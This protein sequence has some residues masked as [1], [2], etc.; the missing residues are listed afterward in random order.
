MDSNRTFIFNLT[1][2]GD[3][4]FKNQIGQSEISQHL[5]WTLV[6]DI[7][8]TLSNRVKWIYLSVKSHRWSCHTLSLLIH[9]VHL[10]QN[11]LMWENNAIFTTHDWEWG[12]HTTKQ[13]MLMTGTWFIRY[14]MHGRSAV[15]FRGINH[16]SD[17]SAH[18]KMVDFPYRFVLVFWGGKHPK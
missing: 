15:R 11:Q 7:W 4:I 3:Y 12:H 16:S 14:G 17:S 18:L 10:T 9:I 8:R 2:K 6:F 5:T 1:S 13:K